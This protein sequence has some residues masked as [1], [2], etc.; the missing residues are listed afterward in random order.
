MAETL[1]QILKRRE[2]RASIPGL[3]FIPD[4]PSEI[5]T[6]TAAA[7]AVP[8]VMS[9][10]IPWSS[11]ALTLGQSAAEAMGP[12]GLPLTS[13]TDV[14]GAPLKSQKY[15]NGDIGYLAAIPDGLKAKAQEL[16]DAADH[17]KG[18]GALRYPVQALHGVFNPA[19]SWLYLLK[20]M[21]GETFDKQSMDLA[22][23]A[24][25]AIRRRLEA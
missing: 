2:K 8:W 25:E 13:I 16:Q 7:T 21:R 10:V 17:M 12:A 9:R 3:S 14:V 20:A 5:A 11:Q 4:S 1:T 6:S 18:W 15:N 22:A 24:E 23:A 19:T